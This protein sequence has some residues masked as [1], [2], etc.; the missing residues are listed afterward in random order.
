MASLTA[1]LATALAF[2][3]APQ[4]AHAATKSLSVAPG[5]STSVRATKTTRTSSIAQATFYAPAASP[6]YL[7]IQLRNDG[8]RSGYRAKASVN[9]GSV[10]VSI[11]RVADS[12]ET[13]LASVSTGLTVKAG[14]KVYVKAAAVGSNPVRIYVKAWTTSTKISGWQLG[15]TDYSSE[16]IVRSGKAYLWAYLGSDA[17]SATAVKYTSVKVKSYSVAKAKKT[18]VGASY[19]SQTPSNSASETPQ[20]TPTPTPTPTTGSTGFPTAATTGVVAGSSLTRHDGDITVTTDGTV[21]QDMD[22][23]GFV[24]V[25]AKNVVIRNCIVRGGKQKGYQVGLITDYGYDNLLIED[26]DVVAEYPS[27]YFDG[28][29][30][31]DYT[32]RRVHVVGNVDSVKIHGD[33]VTVEDSLLENTTYYASDPAQNGGATHN[34]NIQILT[35]KNI[36]I[37]GNT[38]RGATNFA[39]LG[40][41]EQGAVTLTAS[42]NYLDGGWCTVKLQVK[43]GN[44]ETAKVTNNT[45]G[46]NRS[47][48][49]CPFT[50][51]PAVSLTQ[52]GNRFEDG[53]AVIPLI[54]VS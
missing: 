26:V 37:T 50:A 35:G 32:A 33:N 10:S 36:K 19:S 48:S 18:K 9:D 8:V 30:G 27:V 2:G 25:K 46:P 22:I 23:H 34:D 31:W 15:Y 52:S 21:L 47:V 6:A 49:S 4:L 43:N 24:T 1:A 40:G 14:A 16:R 20:P 41:A 44:S 3:V 11:S 28:I 53:S 45:F 42:D 38:I 13:A 39:I 17:G 12:S 5:S 51:Y 54:K 29:K 7:G